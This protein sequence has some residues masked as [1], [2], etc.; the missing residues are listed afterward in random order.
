MATPQ[1]GILLPIP[2]LARYL[3]FSLQPGVNPRGPLRKFAALADGDHL[4]AG[5][6]ESLV[7]ALGRRIVG[8]R[9]FPS[10]T[11]AGF[12]IPSTPSALWVW[13]RGEDRGELF[14]RSRRV[15]RTLAPAF[16]LEQALDAFRHDRSR[17]LTGYEDGTE[18]PKGGKARKAALVAD[19]GLAGSSF[20]A[21]QQW[22][23]Q[24]ERF[25]AM[26]PRQR[27]ATFGR[28]RSSNEE[29]AGAPASAHVKRTAQE[30]FDPEAFVVRRSMPWAEAM[31]AGLVFVSFGSSLDKFEAQLRRMAGLEDGITDA[32][33][34]F[35]RPVSGAYYWCP[36]LRR[37]RL[38]LAPLGL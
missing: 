33:F 9:A 3:T 14:H 1:P 17:D 11:G 31:R 22:E 30:S 37:G 23:H 27:D 32:L 38:D 35:T 2:P 15:E 12:D 26:T 24:F 36:A 16:R 13:A 29:I 10:G 20:V 5:L 4:V 34:G 6:G 18:N 28:R 21:V 8:L 25:E 7:L 19:P